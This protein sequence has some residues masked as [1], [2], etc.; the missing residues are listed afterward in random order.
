MHTIEERDSFHYLGTT[1]DSTVSWPS[2][3]ISSS[4]VPASGEGTTSLPMPAPARALSSVRNLP[5]YL[6]I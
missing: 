5:S 6:Q 3:P 4:S 1:L 2:I